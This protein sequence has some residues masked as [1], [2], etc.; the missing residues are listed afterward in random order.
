M[1]DDIELHWAN[2]T[3]T[4]RSNSEQGFAEAIAVAQRSDAVVMF[5]G[6]ESILSGEAHCRANIYLPGN[7]VQLIE[8]IA[9]TG[10]PI[11]LVVLAG[12]PLTLSNVIDK[13]D[14]VLYAWHP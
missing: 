13:V 12:R 5:V 9:A 10:K 2:G 4:S 8:A 3:Q 7:Q 11:T 6:E 14:A 1:G